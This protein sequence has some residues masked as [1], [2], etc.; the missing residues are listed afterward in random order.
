MKKTIFKILSGMSAAIILITAA[1]IIFAEYGFAEITGTA[2]IS[3]SI[4]AVVLIALSVLA[5]HI[6]SVKIT[7]SI[8]RRVEAID[9]DN[10]PQVE[11]KELLP[12]V[13]RARSKN[14]IKIKTEQ[15]RREFSA[16]VS[17][18]LKTPL[19][20]ISGYAQMINNG[21]AKEED[22][23]KFTKLI[24]KESLRLISL[25]NDIIEISHLDEQSE[26]P[27]AEKIDLSM[28]AAE[29]IASLEKTASEKNI[30]IFYSGSETYVN[31]NKT[32]I[33]ELM[34]NIIDNAVKYNKEN[35]NVTVFVGTIA[36]G[37]V[38]SVK[39]TG[40]GIPKGDIDRIFERF[41]RVDK[42]HSKTVGGTGLG[43]SI[44]KHIA[45]RHNAD[46]KVKS[47]VGVGS[48]V[49]VIFKRAE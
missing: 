28:I 1:A 24:E 38:F 4:T 47:E 13:K 5:A 29:T 49:S 20:S 10:H 21:M 22:I 25:V 35:G 34:S 3:A 14:Q 33:G 9:L 43:L 15:M 40:I 18:E 31:G 19:T 8:V 7:A 17:H 46:V 44:V 37:A 42:S 45:L 2:V 30:Q 32:L 27:E 36:R 11:Y 23:L 26:L 39:D 12:F 6:I 48:T 41:Y 16:N